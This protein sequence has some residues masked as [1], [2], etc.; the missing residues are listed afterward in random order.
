MTNGD[1]RRN[2]SRDRSSRRYKVRYDRLVAVALVLVVLVVLLTSCYKSCSGKGKN[3]NSATSAQTTVSDNTQQSSIVDN[4]ESSNETKTLITGTPGASAPSEAQYTTEIHNASDINR[5]NLVLVNSEHEYKF[6]EGD[7]ELVTLF[8]N[9]DD[10]H[11]HVSDLVTKLDSE[12]L[13]Q[14]NALMDGFYE[15]ESNSDIYVIGGYRTIEEQ[16]DKYYNGNSQFQGGYSDYHTGRTFDIG[17]FPTDGSSSGYYSPTGVYGWIDEHA[18]EHGF[19]VRFPEGKDNST[20][21]RQRAYTYRYVGAPHAVYMKQ[22]NLCLEE[23]ITK[24]KEHTK[25]SP[26][27]V[28]V[29]NKLYNIYYAAANSTGDT[30]VPVPANKTYTVSG[31]NVDGFIITVS[32][33]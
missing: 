27:E 3:K 17:I 14:L 31:N 1:K 15:A 18:A 13:T 11:Y 4:L 26:V 25:D 33:N 23:Y 10:S 8:D 22:N 7:T 6:I 20:G 5:G 2:R 29:G 24:L 30:E 28:T 16:N 19:V 9:H 21:E 32:M 12:T